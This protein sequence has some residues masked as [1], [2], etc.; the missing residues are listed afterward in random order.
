MSVNQP[1][2]TD[3]NTLNSWLNESTKNFFKLQKEFIQ[4]KKDIKEAT[5]LTDL[6]SKLKT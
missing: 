4:L 2:V 6:Q 3:N 5:S 1:P